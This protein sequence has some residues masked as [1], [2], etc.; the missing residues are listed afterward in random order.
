MEKFIQCYCSLIGIYKNP[1]IAECDKNGLL[2]TL[3]RTQTCKTQNVKHS[4][5]TDSR[6]NIKHKLK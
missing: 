4:Y 3:A 2:R 1:K 5:I 6:S